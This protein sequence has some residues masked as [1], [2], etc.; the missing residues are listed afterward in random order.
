[1]SMVATED[2]AKDHLEHTKEQSGLKRFKE[3]MFDVYI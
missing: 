2:D 1:M 3:I